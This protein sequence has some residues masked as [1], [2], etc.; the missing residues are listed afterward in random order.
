MNGFAAVAV[1]MLILAVGIVLFLLFSYFREK[2]S[3]ARRFASGG[4]GGKEIESRWNASVLG[5]IKDPD[6]IRKRMEKDSEL[7]MLLWQAGI[8]SNYRK[9][10]YFFASTLL[11]FLLAGAGILY[12]LLS[13]QGLS[14]PFL[15]IVGL[16]IVGI[17][18]PKRVVG[19]V[20]N[21]RKRSIVDEVPVFI[22]VLKILF[23]AGLAVEQ[24]LRIISDEARKALPET[25]K[26]LDF[27][28]RRTST[29]LDLSEELD[30]GARLL[31]IDEYS[32]VISILKQM[33]RQGGSARGSLSKL[34]ELIEDRR[35]TGLQEKVNKLSAKMAMVM[36]LFMFPALLI[37]IAA[38]GFMAITKAFGNM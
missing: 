34:S 9:S 27:V 4:K 14:S 15:M 13:A 32:D 2:S 22:Q 18:L 3:V 10:V 28:L 16:V 23:D 31:Q 7:A 37:V 6:V 24:S 1:I 35:M 36:I 17:L 33:I 19:V 29:G 8:R 21:A 20:A 38:P 26:E 12:H 30:Y 5:I 11:P 25:T